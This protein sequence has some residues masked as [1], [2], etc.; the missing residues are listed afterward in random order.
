M[1]ILEF[2]FFGMGI[3][4][5]KKGFVN[6]TKVMIYYDLLIRVILTHHCIWELLNLDHES[7]NTFPPKLIDQSKSTSKLS[8]Y[9]RNMQRF[10]K[11]LKEF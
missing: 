11:K 7:A 5:Q 9:V 6:I 8:Q 4:T 1:G 2:W 10:W 3:K